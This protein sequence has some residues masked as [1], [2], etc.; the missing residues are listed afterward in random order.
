ML[1]D[2]FIDIFLSEEEKLLKYVSK[3]GL[4][5]SKQIE[6]IELGVRNHLKIDKLRFYSNPNFTPEK[7]QSIRI[8]LENN[9]T[10]EQVN[11]LYNNNF[12]DEQIKQIKID[13]KN[14]LTFE[15]LKFMYNNDFTY[16]QIS[17]IK[18]GFKHNLTFNEVK[19]YSNPNFTPEKMQ[20]IRIDLENNLTFEQVNFLY[21]NNFS[22]NEI[23]CIKFAF[24]VGISKEIIEDNINFNN[25][26]DKKISNKFRDEIFFRK[27][28][29][30]F[31]DNQVI[32]NCFDE[33]PHIKENLEKYMLE[34]LDIEEIKQ[35]L[36]CKT[37]ITKD[38][39]TNKIAEM[40]MAK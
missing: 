12:T 2:I 39:L 26:Y 10:F 38:D 8:D 23:C 32:F 22:E 20:R 25:E 16:E 31:L 35:I 11:F 33:I 36:Q 9:L 6:Q 18:I 13:L 34:N 30:E 28:L 40:R 4:F 37:K 14:N 7:M 5:S 1:F 27:S 17:Q 19:F 3:T 24:I 21:N 29:R 15:Q